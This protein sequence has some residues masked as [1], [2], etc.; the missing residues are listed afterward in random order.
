VFFAWS[1]TNCVQAKTSPLDD[2]SIRRLQYTRL[3][4]DAYDDTWELVARNEREDRLSWV[5]KWEY[6]SCGRGGRHF[7]SR[8][9]AGS[10]TGRS[11]TFHTL[12]ADRRSNL[13]ER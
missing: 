13:Y 7:C 9:A 12:S 6:F 2:T 8:R 10:S 5:D 11:H 3:G 1:Q 4:S